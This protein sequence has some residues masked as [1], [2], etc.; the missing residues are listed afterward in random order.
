MQVFHIS[1]KDPTLSRYLQPSTVYMVRK[2]ELE[3]GLG[4]GHSMWNAGVP[5]GA[6][7]E[8]SSLRS[9]LSLPHPPQQTVTQLEKCLFGQC[10]QHP[11]KED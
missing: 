11:L 4:P 1:S 10:T 2:L 7:S 5:R 8:G 6:L 3:T 9:F